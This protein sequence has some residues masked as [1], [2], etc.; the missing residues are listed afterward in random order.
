M[1]PATMTV[2]L[3]AHLAAAAYLMSMSGDS[4]LVVTTD[5]SPRAPLG[6]ITDW[7]IT[8]AVARGEDLE[9]VRISDLLPRQTVTVRPGTS[10][11]EA[12]RL[13]LEMGLHHLVVASD[14]GV[15]G[16]VDTM[17]MCRALIGSAQP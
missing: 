12:T 7:D 3:R 14:P 13:M 16:I 2:E 10:V 17:D 6:V 15:V 1:R 8:Q 5:G 4:A 11:D 9:A